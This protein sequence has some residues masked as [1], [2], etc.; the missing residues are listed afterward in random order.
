MEVR[1]FAPG[2]YRYV[3]GP[4][5]YSAGIAAEPGF[6]LRRVRFRRPLPVE[7]GFSRIEAHLHAENRPLTALCACELRSPAPFTDQ[8]FI[9]FNRGYVGTLERWGLFAGEENPVAR[10]NVCPQVRKPSEPSFEA[11]TYT[12][13]STGR[14]PS[15]QFVIAGSGEAEEKDGPYKDKTVRYGDTT[16][17]AMREKAVFVLDVMER[18]LAALGFGWRDAMVT[19]VYCVFDIYPFLADEI[20]RRGAIDH[21]LT[22]YYARP[23]VQGLDYEM[24]VRCVG[25]EMTVDGTQ[26][27]VMQAS[28]T[29]G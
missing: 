7:E 10:S 6:E 5:Q 3:R 17:D 12:V 22:W 20:D 9:D 29:P 8:G 11:F 15:G 27:A 14:E 18:R 1:T 16:G 24:D 13:P 28:P 19:Q 4:F 23:P 25:A 2:G 21:G 26:A